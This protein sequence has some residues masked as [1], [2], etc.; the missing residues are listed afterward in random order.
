MLIRIVITQVPHPDLID[1]HTRSL[2]LMGIQLL[3]GLP[4]GGPG[5]FPR[6]HDQNRSIQPG[7]ED[8]GIADREQRRRVDEDEIKGLPEPAD[9]P[10][11]L[12][13]TQE[14]DGI[15]RDGPGVDQGKRRDRRYPQQVFQG[16][17]G[18]QVLG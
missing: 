17:V 5:G 2:D 12:L 18:G 4:Q 3:S 1:D 14:L 9:Q 8:Q 11:H 16:Q 15:G 13:G 7:G 6:P 10:G